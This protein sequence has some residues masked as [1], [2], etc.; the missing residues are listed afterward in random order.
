VVLILPMLNRRTL[1][2][3]SAAA[4]LP[5]R[6]FADDTAR[7]QAGLDEAHAAGRP[8]VLPA[9]Q[10]FSRTLTLRDGA[11]LIGRPGRSVLSLLGNEPL[12]LLE[13]QQRITMEG[14]TFDGGQAKLANELGLVT[15][16]AV[17]DL[18]IDDCEIREA[19][20]MGLRL[21]ASG[22]R[23][24]RSKILN[25]KSTALFSLDAKGL[26]ITG[27]SVSGAGD[28]GI[29][30]WRGEKGDDGTIVA[31]NR[32]ND[33]RADSGGT[34]QNGNAINIYKAG[35]VIVSDNEI[36]RCRF[37]A[38]RNN[39]GANVQIQGNSCIGFEESAIWHEFNFDGGT[40][41]NNIV[42]GAMIGLIITNYGSDNGRLATVSGN[43]IRDCR[44]KIHIGDGTEGGGI[45]IKA[46]GEI[47]ITGNAIEAADFC[48]IQIGWATAMDRVAC[49]GN[50]VNAPEVG[51]GVS[52]VPGAGEA[53]IAGN[54]I[55]RA[56]RAIAGFAFDKVV[57]GDLL[58]DGAKAFPKI[59][60]QGNAAS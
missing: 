31:Q 30:I 27:N 13:G 48:G 38:V 29:L 54:T 7:L 23:I 24:E 50:M 3:S 11:H 16:R 57:T 42:E 33:I 59:T 4:L 20:G 55:A 8:F 46:E 14:V 1:L 19:G 56:K 52:V 17:Q 43:I 6:A 32:I 34:G 26:A 58:K 5:K 22:G 12:L 28:N 44:R 18:R 10:L 47:A 45:A 9:G 15:A 41:A 49:T 21:E 51:I 2:F 40:I 35:G 36:R 39:G 37:S 53:V 60:L 25:A